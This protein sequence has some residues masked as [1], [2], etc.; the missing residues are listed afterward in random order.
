M[1]TPWWPM[2]DMSTCLGA[3]L[4]RSSTTN[5][6]GQSE[7]LTFNNDIDVLRFTQTVFG[8]EV[9]TQ[10]SPV[11]ILQHVEDYDLCHLMS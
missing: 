11:I 5:C 8:S 3:P 1:V 6:T 4:V 2:T 9:L 7:P 10:H